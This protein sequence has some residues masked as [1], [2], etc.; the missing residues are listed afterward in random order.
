MSLRHLVLNMRSK[1]CFAWLL[2]GVCSNVQA[3]N[4]V[5]NIVPKV[6]FAPSSRRSLG[7]VAFIGSGEATISR[8]LKMKGLFCRISSVL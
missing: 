4:V 2:S 7:C 6:R 5:V 1:V 3:V 8:L